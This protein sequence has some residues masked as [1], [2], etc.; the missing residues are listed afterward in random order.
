MD[1]IGE[2]AG[3]TAGSKDTT[4]QSFCIVLKRWLVREYV[5]SGCLLVARMLS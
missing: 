5:W 1:G 4:L 3:T 2:A